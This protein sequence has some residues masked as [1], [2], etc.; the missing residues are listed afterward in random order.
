M[1]SWFGKSDRDD[2]SRDKTVW[3]TRGRIYGITNQGGWVACMS[4]IH[5]R[6]CKAMIF[7]DSDMLSARLS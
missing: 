1:A 5:G 2:K 3:F 6:V 4:G 7:N